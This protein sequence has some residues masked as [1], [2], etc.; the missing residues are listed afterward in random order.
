MYL[1]GT[2]GSLLLERSR[3]WSEITSTPR[4]IECIYQIHILF[5]VSILFLSS[6]LGGWTSD[7]VHGERSSTTKLQ[8]LSLQLLNFT[9]LPKLKRRVS[10]F[11]FLH[12]F[13]YWE[14]TPQSMCRGERT[15]CFS[16]HYKDPENRTLIVRSLG[17]ES[18]FTCWTILQ[19]PW[20]RINYLF[21]K[22]F[23]EF[24]TLNLS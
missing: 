24:V 18:A 11:L 10:F 16:L 12:L 8:P 17:L 14:G 4:I 19:A 23:D 9:R 15:T 2:V 22:S 20:E 1:Q 3:P 21:M 7:L 6:G 13:M 5:S